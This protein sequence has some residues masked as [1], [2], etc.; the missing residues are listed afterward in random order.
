M[1]TV[2]LVFMP[3]TH[4]RSMVAIDHRVTMPKRFDN[5]KTNSWG[6]KK[7][8]ISNL[9]GDDSWTRIGFYKDLKNDKNYPVQIWA[10]AKKN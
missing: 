5:I 10:I 2:W 7:C 9:R 3:F 8:V 1:R 4:E 6:N